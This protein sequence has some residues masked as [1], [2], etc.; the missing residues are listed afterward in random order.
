MFNTKN[1]EFLDYSNN[2]QRLCILP[3]GHGLRL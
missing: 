2:G 3:W 1:T